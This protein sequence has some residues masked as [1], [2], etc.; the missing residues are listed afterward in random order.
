M[1]RVS[2]GKSKTKTKRKPTLATREAQ[3]DKSHY[4]HP[5]PGGYKKELLSEKHLESI[6]YGIGKEWTPINSRKERCRLHPTPRP[7]PLGGARK[8]RIMEGFSECSSSDGLT[9]EQEREIAEN[10]YDWWISGMSYK[11]WY[12][13]KFLQYQFNFSDKEYEK[14]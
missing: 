8:Q 4:S 10:I 7:I 6:W 13:K 12:A 9:D 1:H 14:E 3:L 2:N 5:N 11:K